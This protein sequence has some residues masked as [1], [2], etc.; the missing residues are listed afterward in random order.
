MKQI[1]DPR[2]LS[3]D[4]QNRLRHKITPYTGV[5]HN[6]DKQKE[7]SKVGGVFQ[8]C[9]VD[10]S[11]QINVFYSVLYIVPPAD[12]LMYCR[13]TTTGIFAC[14]LLKPGDQTR[15]FPRMDPLSMSGF[16]CLNGPWLTWIVIIW[17]YLSTNSASSSLAWLWLFCPAKV[18][19]LKEGNRESLLV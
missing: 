16:H 10:S 17:S 7:R 14:S 15:R 6:Y 4:A 18:L 1:E 13:S 11:E 2:H 9:K 8:H 19:L 3:G 12:F 5:I